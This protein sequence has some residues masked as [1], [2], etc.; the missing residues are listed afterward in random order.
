MPDQAPD[1]DAPE[2]ALARFAIET[3]AAALPSEMRALARLS[4]LDW[5]AVSYRGL[6]EPVSRLVRQMLVEDGGTPEATVLGTGWRLPA[7]AAAMANGTTSHAL[8]YDDTSFVYLGHPSAAVLPAALALAERTHACEETFIDAALI[9]ME[10]ACRVGAWLGRSHYQHGFHQTATAGTFGAT[11]AA[12]RLLGL[13][14]TQ[15]EHAIGLASSRASGL[16]SQFGSMGKPFH[17]GM[18]A[19]N[20]VEAARLARAGFTSNPRGL[21]GAQG[22]ALTHQA[23][24][25]DPA[26]DLTLFGSDY[27]FASVQ[28]KFHACCHGLH[29]PIEAMLKLQ[30][31]HALDATQVRAISVATHPR[32]LTVCNNASP[33]TGLEAKFS[34]RLA[35]AMALL[36]VDTG[37]LDVYTDE[38]CQR[39]DLL[40]MR[41]KV[42]VRPDQR[43]SDSAAIITVEC[44]DGQTLTASHD[45]AAPLSFAQRKERVLRKAG[46]LLGETMS[47]D[48]WLA[49]DEADRPAGHWLDLLT[50]GN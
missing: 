21:S 50:P 20:G 7:R 28:H 29:A 12:A 1:T 34:F 11:A 45:L 23:K 14:V 35:A 49:L 6:N 10:T 41:D 47:T 36:G 25:D 30:A 38:L 40:A 8:D 3:D 44:T 26:D 18:A 22:F 4:L 13:N 46:S 48:L 37:N 16:K 43:L 31:R 15:T 9:G 42:S 33:S 2:T 27:A 39:A 17:A 19:A 32:F 24:P 5:I